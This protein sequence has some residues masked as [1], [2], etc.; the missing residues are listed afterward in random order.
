MVNI[1]TIETNAPATFPS[2]RLLRVQ[3]LSIG[4]VLTGLF[5]QP[6]SGDER[7]VK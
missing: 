4:L 7:R 3:V 6:H 2:R 1:R 5:E